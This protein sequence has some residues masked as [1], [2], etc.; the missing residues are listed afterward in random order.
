MTRCIFCNR[1]IWFRYD[2]TK[3]PAH[4]ICR[5]VNDRADRLYKEHADRMNRIVGSPTT[6]EIYWLYCVPYWQTEESFKIKS[7]ILRKRYNKGKRAWTI[8]V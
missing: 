4:K 2:Q 7:E 5:I 8:R 6:E 3:A 1:L